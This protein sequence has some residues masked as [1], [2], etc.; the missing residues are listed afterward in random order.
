MAKNQ[1]A[2][3]LEMGVCSMKAIRLEMQDGSPVAT[4]YDFIDH[5][6][7][8]SQPE[9]L[10]DQDKMIKEALLKFLSRNKV[11]G[12]LVCLS[13]SSQSGLARFV[14]LPPVEESK[15][16]EIVR[17]EAKQQI[18]FPLNEV[19]WDFQKLGSG[20]VI[21]GLALDSEIGLFA[22]K[23]DFINKTL[24]N[25]R[26]VNI[27]L[28]A[29]QMAP[30]AL[31]NYIAFDVMGKNYKADGSPA[32]ESDDD[33]APKKGIL[34]LDIGN[35]I[36]NL[37]LT[38]GTKIIE[39]RS[40]SIGGSRFTKEIAKEFK[41]TFAKAEHL[42]RT[43]AK[44]TTKDGPDL[45]AVITAVKPIFQDLVGEL[46]RSLTYFSNRH[47]NIEFEY[48]L[49]LG[50]GFKLHGLQRFLQ[51]KLGVE[52]RKP[53]TFERLKGDSV[54]K[55]T[56]FSDN[57]LTFAGAY[58]LALQGLKQV[59]MTTNL[60]PPEIVAE[61][62]LKMKRP[63]AVA[64]AAAVLLGLSTYSL[65]NHLQARA[66]TDPTV[67]KSIKEGERIIGDVSKGKKNFEEA[68]SNVAKEESNVKSL[69][70]GQDERFNWLD[71]FTYLNEAIPRQDGKNLSDQQRAAYWNVAQNRPRGEA[72]FKELV[73]R[74]TLS[75]D[76]FGNDGYEPGDT[77]GKN[78][79]QLIE[80]NIESVDCKFTEN[81]SGY[82]Q[83]V[84]GGAKS[85][86][87]KVKED[88]RPIEHW[89]KSPDGAGWVVELRGY[90]FQQD[91]KRFVQEVLLENLVRYGIVKN[92]PANNA[93]APAAGAG[94]PDLGPVVNRVSH[95][96]VYK[97]LTKKTN[98]RT[99]FEI[100]GQSYLA[101]AMRAGGFGEGGGGGGGP[102][103][104]PPGSPGGPGMMSGDGGGD[105]GA[106]AGAA[107]RDGWVPV[108]ST[109][110]AA[111]AGG[112]GR[113]GMMG[114]G[115][116]GMMGGGPGENPI[117][118]GGA[119]STATTTGAKSNHTRTEF[120]ILFIWK[121]PTPSDAMRAPV[122]EGADPTAAS[123]A[124]AIGGGA[125]LTSTGPGKGVPRGVIDPSKKSI[126]RPRGDAPGNRPYLNQPAAVPVVPPPQ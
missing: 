123:P 119:A 2:W 34:G 58:G 109:G 36:S 10:Q 49:A 108:G 99:N 84:K 82:W 111:S 88:V 104:P 83:Q 78:I 66:W 73:R 19:V 97:Y 124:D 57:L 45:K 62:Q 61:R 24:L 31:I 7:I 25:Y 77:L 27:D 33:D 117:G 76:E 69:L 32:I 89:E 39:Q 65:K 53:G 40:I 122:G 101:N 6:K 13:V 17:F 5:A 81:L 4:H 75:R 64:A 51:E 94:L 16:A 103:M 43:I 14:K 96:L 92:G 50:N 42:K 47:R 112:F 3:G 118:P 113:G 74:Q 15:I 93:E 37:V 102:S 87:R 98:E 90:T 41:L 116:G 85:E 79:D 67:A 71:L 29:V 60:L 107:S 91:Q 114:G 54:I 68:K 8:L 28:H 9:N 120:V 72:A 30:L 121:E 59:R 35:D 115:P 26:E 70:S 1:G 48:M 44:A 80:F 38:D 126:N 105:S 100:I 20:M 56:N 46:Q 95:V 55:A 63:W 11:R 12:D 21:D 23:R 18:P 52:L 106:G 86:E 125:G 110:S 22:M